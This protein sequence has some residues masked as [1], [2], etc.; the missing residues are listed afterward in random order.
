MIESHFQ[1][2]KESGAKYY[3]TTYDQILKGIINGPLIHADET[4]APLQHHIKGYVWAFANMDSVAYLYRP[5]R[6]GDFLGE[7]L[8]DFEGVL[9]SDFY[10]AYDSLNCLQQKCLV[11]LMR[12]LNVDMKLLTDLD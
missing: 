8:K 5:T 6:K 4:G 11:H 3:R 9:V 1:D 12:D 10:T 2:I 7:L